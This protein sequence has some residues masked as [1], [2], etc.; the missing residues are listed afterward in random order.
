MT[1]ARRDSSRRTAADEPRAPGL[2]GYWIQSFIGIALILALAGSVLLYLWISAD[3]AEQRRRLGNATNTL[4][5]QVTRD[6][7]RIRGQVE[8][9]RTDPELRAVFRKPGNAE[10]RRMQEATLLRCLPGALSIHLFSAEQISSAEGIPFM[11]Y[12]GLDLARKAVQ[13]RTL[14]PI[15]VHKV[16]QQDMH[17]AVA[18]PVL[19]EAGE[20]TLGVVHIALPMRL[21]PTVSAEGTGQSLTLF[22]QVVGENIASLGQ[23]APSIP[24]EYTARIGGS[25]LR[26]AAW[27]IASE[28]LKLTVLLVAGG[29]YL[30]A[31]GLIVGVLWI[32]YSA[33]RR[34]LLLDSKSFILLIEDA[35][36][37]RPLRRIRS[38]ISEIQ[39]AHEE[40]LARLRNLAAGRPSPAPPTE[41]FPAS[42]SPLS[43]NG[44]CPTSMLSAS[45]IEV[46]EIELPPGL[47]SDVDPL[48]EAP[49]SQ[50]PRSAFKTP[51]PAPGPQY[52]PLIEV[53]A[54]VFRVNDIRGLIQEQL[55]PEVVEAIGR[56]LGTLAAE[57]GDREVM[58][59]HDAR[60]DS[61][62]LSE[63]LTAGIRA[64]GRDV[65][66]LGQVPTPL[67]Y[68]AC[69]HPAA[70]SGAIVTAGNNPPEYNGVKCMLHGAA[71]EPEEIQRL[72]RI[73][74][75]GEAATGEGRYRTADITAAYLSYVEQDV[76]LGRALRLV[77]DC[78]N[79]TTSTL[80]PALFR[81]LGCEVIEFN[82]DPES[83][84]PE[85]LSD[86]SRPE[87]LQDLSDLVTARSADLGLAFDGDGDRL[88]VVDSQGRFV[89]ADRVLLLLAAD[90]LTRY[91]GSDVVYDVKCSRHLASE[92]RRHGGRPTMWRSGHGPIKAKVRDS[93]ALIGGELSGHIVFK[94]RWFGFDD[95]LYAGARLLEVL[96]RDPRPTDE[97]FAALPGGIVTPEVSMPIPEG[98]APRIM[99]AVMQLASRLEGVDVIR[100]DGLRAEFDRGFGLVRA[101]G[102]E[103]KLTFCFEGDDAEALEKIQ[104]LFRRMMKKVMRGHA[105]PF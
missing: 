93:S 53:P 92:I 94:E 100:I 59:G 7:T 62:D 70:T 96:S 55:T 24:P 80:A 81:A 8:S 61:P 97:V 17:L 72:R 88:G 74:E 33:Q 31:L 13:D 40:S 38:H 73:I 6:M 23:S 46:A 22:Q 86:P 91:P 71:A 79:A 15:E 84:L 3:S 101:S 83:D 44:L 34:A 98:E 26:V 30:T 47:G 10:A 49:G 32:G 54:E 69:C 75:T 2:R 85:R 45:S 66:D 5:A 87:C 20:R 58:I 48:D 104:G 77:I 56:A 99:R 68:F 37:G 9:W 36:Q 42:S 41:P 12:A 39:S 16:G 27:L 14:T 89:A 105:I 95:A 78:G 4:A 35:V 51:T 18:V 52:H 50:S 65:V 63:A 102:T 82:C 19:D 11:S 76:A 103:P 21:L 25:R 1:A 90:V 60:P 57:Q 28:D 67:V 43:E 64:A 29:L